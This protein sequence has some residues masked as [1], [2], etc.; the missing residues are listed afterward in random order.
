MKTHPSI[1]LRFDNEARRA[2]LAEE[3]QAQSRSLNNY[4][5]HLLATHPDRPKKKGGE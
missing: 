5:L 1:H 3:A 2:A 4:V